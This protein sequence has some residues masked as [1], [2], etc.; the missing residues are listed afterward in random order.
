MEALR[1]DNRADEASTLLARQ[2]KDGHCSPALLK[3]ARALGRS[4][5]LLPASRADMLAVAVNCA[6]ADG[7]T[8][9][10]KDLLSIDEETRK[11]ADPTRN[12]KLLLF[13]A[14]LSLK[15]DKPA[16]LLPLVRGEGFIDRFLR[17]S[18]NAVAGALILHHAAHVLNG[19]A[20][21]PAK[22]Q[23]AYS[24]VCESFP[25]DD[26]RAECDDLAALRDGSKPAATRKD[27]AKAA[28][29]RLLAPPPSPPAKK[30]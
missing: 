10:E 14:Q 22:T 6:G 23:G 20:F 21:D 17:M 29:E 13:V 25:S 4:A 27:L 19:E 18:G 5:L 15:A 7:G 28:L 3:T 12:L 26:R 9:L 11:L 1:A 2:R 24:L 30:P 8:E 16:L